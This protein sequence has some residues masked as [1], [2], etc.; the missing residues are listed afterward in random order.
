MINEHKKGV[1]A[2]KYTAKAKPANPVAKNAGSTTISSAGSHY[3]GKDQKKKSKHGEQKHKKRELETHESFDGGGEYN[4]E[5]SMVR[6]NLHTIVRCAKELNSMLSDDE[7]M[8]EW[9][10]EKIAVA[11]NTMARVLDYVASEHEQG[12]Q[13][14]I[15]E[16]FNR[17]GNY[18]Q[19]LT[20]LLEHANTTPSRNKR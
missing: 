18:E 20:K 3:Q 7:N 1:K 12:N 8:A 14:S 10:Q 17:N 13:Y 11:A 4:D 2:M 15:S 6:N 9:V 19:Y 16:Q 5:A